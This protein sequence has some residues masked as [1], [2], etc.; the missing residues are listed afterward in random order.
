MKLERGGGGL[1]A[2]LTL[3]KPNPIFD[4][5]M[6]STV[7]EEA[8]LVVGPEGRAQHAQ[9]VQEVAYFFFPTISGAAS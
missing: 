5:G 6:A 8:D 9:N 2:S 7:N 3:T 1:G 4:S